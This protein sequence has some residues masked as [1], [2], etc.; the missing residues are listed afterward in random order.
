MVAATR[1]GTSNDL[2][3]GDSK[4]P[5]DLTPEQRTQRARVAALWMHAKNDSRATSAPGRTAFMARFEDM[6]DPDRVLP[7]A[8]RRRRADLAKRAHF[9]ALAYKS[10]K[11]R[12]KGGT[13]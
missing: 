4:V 12:Q 11:A 8:E 3:R 2:R 10:A 5:T 7:E 13:G 1:M 9:Q 6:V